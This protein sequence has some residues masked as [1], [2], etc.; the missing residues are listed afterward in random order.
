MFTLARLL[1]IGI[2]AMVIVGCA[3]RPASNP[4]AALVPDSQPID[5]KLSKPTLLVFRLTIQSSYSDNE[6]REAEEDRFDTV[7][8]W[9]SENET[10]R[11]KTF[12]IDQ[13]I[14]VHRISGAV[15]EEVAL[16]NTMKNYDDVI[17]SMF[18]VK[19]DDLNDETKVSQ[20]MKH[21]GGAAALEVA[22]NG[23]NFAFWNPKHVKYSSKT[24]PR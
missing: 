8:W 17:A 24:Q 21:F 13:D 9:I 10:W 19:F 22:R 18:T 14:H 7:Q 2:V 5:A 4:E 11:I 6:E 15:P 16:D 3:T 1:V 12:A 20:A 23:E